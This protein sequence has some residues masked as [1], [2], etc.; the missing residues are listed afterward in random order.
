L[1]NEKFGYYRN[2]E[3]VIGTRGDFITAPEISQ[4]FGELIGVWIKQVSSDFNIS[5]SSDSIR[6]VELGPG[7]GTLMVDLLRVSRS[8]VSLLHGQHPSII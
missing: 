5:S 1:A 2:K 7:K 6:I 3:D 8:H 4:V